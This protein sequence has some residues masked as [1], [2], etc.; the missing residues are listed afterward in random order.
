MQID[1]EQTSST[2]KVK[3]SD[4][5]SFDEIYK[6]VAITCFRY[7]D[8]KSLDQVDDL[9]IKEFEWMMEAH[10]LKEVDK[11][12]FIHLQAFKNFQATATKKVGKRQKPMYSR[13]EK[14]FDYDKAIEQ[15]KGIHKEENSEVT[16]L[17]DF[18]K[19]KMKEG[20]DNG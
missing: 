2:R 19:H 7:L 12:Y 6:Q 8:F 16:R 13:F 10:R 11:I 9:T 14:F 15:A 18:M 3:S 17:K 4:S 5:I 1:N 20:D